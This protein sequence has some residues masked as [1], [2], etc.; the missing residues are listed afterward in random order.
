[1]GV[2]SVRFRRIKSGLDSF[3]DTM[4]QTSAADLARAQNTLDSLGIGSPRNRRQTMHD[5]MRSS[6]SRRR[7]TSL[8][9]PPMRRV[10]SS[11][12]VRRH[13]GGSRGVDSSGLHAGS[14]ALV[15]SGTQ[16]SLAEEPPQDWDIL[17]AFS[18]SLH[19]AMAQ[20][21]RPLFPSLQ[22]P[23]L[24]DVSVQTINCMSCGEVQ[25]VP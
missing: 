16:N 22:A 7:R 24:A 18:N 12:D 10:Q 8:A 2:S 15:K 5:A 19:V 4:R 20:P 23:A 21:P 11:V 13:G 25:S 1:M 14:K 3:Q 6:S 17:Q 9:G